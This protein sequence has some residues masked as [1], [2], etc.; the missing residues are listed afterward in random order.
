VTARRAAE[1]QRIHDEVRRRIHARVWPPGSAIPHETALAAE[2]GV[3]R[4]TVNRALQA[5]AHAGW[6]DRR[7]RAGTRVAVHPAGQARFAIAIIRREIEEAGRTYGH[8]L[9]ERTIG[10]PPRPVTDALALPADGA[11][12]HLTALHRADGAPYAF[13][14]R[15]VNPA[16][17][18][19]LCD[20]PLAEENANEWLLA[21]VPFTHGTLRI[22]AAHGTPAATAALSACDRDPLLVLERSTWDGARPVTW[23]RLT[24]APGHAL[25]APL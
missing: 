20:A 4:A 23:V 14:D 2:F 8:T 12:L 15:W 16:V 7:R 21:N 25:R 11:L 22:T 10:V 18:P 6:L 19:D 5:L 3:A 1:W 9:L 24:F 17:A 13:E